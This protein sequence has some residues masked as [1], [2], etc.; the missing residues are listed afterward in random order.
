M[1]SRFEI[2]YNQDICHINEAISELDLVTCSLDYDF[3][4]IDVIQKLIEITKKRWSTFTKDMFKSYFPSKYQ[5]MRLSD[6]PDKIIEEDNGTFTYKFP[7]SSNKT[8]LDLD[9]ALKF[10]SASFVLMEY[11]YLCA[12]AFSSNR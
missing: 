9:S 1:F 6:I 10:A 3:S 8:K 7:C 5:E 2:I 4:S 11:T 12:V